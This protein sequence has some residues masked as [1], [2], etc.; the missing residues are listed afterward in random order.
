[1][2]SVKLLVGEKNVRDNCEVTKVIKVN[3][4][5]EVYKCGFV[6]MIGTLACLVPPR[7]GGTSHGQVCF[8]YPSQMVA[9]CLV[10]AKSNNSVIFTSEIK[11]KTCHYQNNGNKVL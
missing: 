6:L 4:R 2:W 8:T 10:I 9:L 1:M 11:K 5:P 7:P 3:W